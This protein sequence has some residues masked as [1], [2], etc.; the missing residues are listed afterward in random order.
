MP[1]RSVQILATGA[2]LPPLADAAALAARAGLGV[3]E[4]EALAGVRQ[5]HAVTTETATDLGVGAA[6]AALDAAGL[7][8]EDLDLVLGA[9]GSRAQPLPGPAVLIHRGLG[10]GESG[11]PALDVDSTCLSFVSALDVAAMWIAAGRARRVLVVSAEVATAAVDWSHPESAGLFGDGAAAVVLG[12][13]EDGDAAL[14]AARHETYSH[15][16]DWCRVRGGGTALPPRAPGATD[17]DFLFEMDGPRLFRLA[18]HALPDFAER[19]V[20]DAGLDL[21]AIDLVIPHQASA[22]TLRLLGRRLGVEDRLVSIVETHG[23]CV[24][25][26]IPLALHHAVTA[27]RLRRGDTALLIGTSAGVSLGGLVLRY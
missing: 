12:P 11:V 15:A 5:R 17:A 25:A 19:L 23:N 6:R 21:D 10:L 18:A 26:S 3:A 20:A 22:S 27:G 8:P 7:A 16:A 14:L 1:P 9:C 2:H 24:A 4:L 13:S